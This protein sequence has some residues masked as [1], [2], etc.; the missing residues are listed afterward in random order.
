LAATG[1]R[2]YAG[3]GGGGGI[4]TASA[5]RPRRYSVGCQAPFHESIS[6]AEG[7]ELLSIEVGPGAQHAIDGV[8]ELPHDG[9]DGLQPGLLSAE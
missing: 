5:V 3:D 7:V 6:P 1:G 8:K 2:P 4:W 9:D